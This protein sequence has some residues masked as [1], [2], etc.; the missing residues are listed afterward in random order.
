MI[1]RHDDPLVEPL[2]ALGE[3]MYLLDSNP[4][5]ERIA[6]LIYEQGGRS[7]STSG[8]A[9]LETR[10]WL[11]IKKRRIELKRSQEASS[12]AVGV[13]ESAK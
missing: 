6:E 5:V 13:A 11:R 12:A 7:A 2:R 9:R 10:R 1:L 3:P 4:T 8:R